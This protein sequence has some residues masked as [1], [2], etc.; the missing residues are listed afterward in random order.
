MTRIHKFFHHRECAL[1]IAIFFVLLVVVGNSRAVNIFS[2]GKLPADI[3][4]LFVEAEGEVSLTTLRNIPSIERTPIFWLDDHRLIFTSR[5]FEEWS[6]KRD[7][8]SKIIVYDTET[9]ISSATPYRGNLYCVGPSGELAV[10]DYP[11]PYPGFLLPADTNKENLTHF[12]I[13][14]FGAELKKIVLDPDTGIEMIGYQLHS[15]SG[16]NF[17]ENHASVRLY[18]DDGTLDVGSYAT[19]GSTVKLVDTAGKTRWSIPN[20]F[21]NY[22]DPSRRYLPW[23]R[24]YFSGVSFGGIEPGCPDPNL[25][26]WLFSSTNVQVKPLPQLVQ[27]GRKRGYGMTGVGA[28]YWAKNGMYIALHSTA[29]GLLDGIYWLD[30]SSGQ[31]KRILKKQW[32]LDVISPNGCR[33]LVKVKPLVVIELC[34]KE[35]NK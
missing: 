27:E 8:K 18:G 3:R 25:N 16:N 26:S 17:G 34:K 11:V 28:T 7:E 21:C 10:R 15:N 32:R 12:L 31:L 4:D 13:G 23:S 6:A 30:E 1:S 22:F 33:N 2:E 35:N 24:Q 14:Q 29:Y 19:P 5:N 9:G 20:K